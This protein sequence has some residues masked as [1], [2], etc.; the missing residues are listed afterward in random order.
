MRRGS[1]RVRSGVLASVVIL[2][3]CGRK[4][5]ELALPE[6]Q[7]EIARTPERWLEEPSIRLLRDYVRIDTT[8]PPGRERPGAAFLKEY[9]DCEGVAS[10]LVCAEKDRCNLYA[11]IP[12]KN[13]NRALLLLNHIDVVPAY[14][15]D[16]KYPV[17]E[18]VIDRSYLYGRGVYDMKSIGIAQMLAFV[19]LAHS[20]LQPERDVVFLA[21]CG[22]EYG[23]SDGVSWIFE[24]RPELLSGVDCVLNEGGYEETVAG[25]PRNWQ[26]E[27]GQGGS[28]TVIFGSDDPEKLKFGPEIED[29]GLFVSPEPAV[30]RYFSEIAEFRQPFLLRAYRNPESIRNPEI[31]H[32][33]PYQQLS[34]LAGGVLRSQPFS[35][36]YLPGYPDRGKWIAIVMVSLPLGID[37]RPYFDR[38]LE[39]GRAK[40]AGVV[41]SLVTPTGSASPYPS[42]ETRAIQRAL[43]AEHPGV[44]VLPLINSF[45]E[46][47]STEFRKRGIAAYGFTPFEIDPSDAA[48]RHGNDERVFLPFFVRGVET[49]RET[50]FEIVD[51]ADKN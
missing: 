41:F 44:P 22:E 15:P 21:E 47:T 4:P 32:W 27:I 2:A 45:S 5:P 37:P 48:R 12:G 38:L 49:M 24:H 9:L 16:W 19:D 14:R 40:G 42:P 20:G 35:A 18:G 46:T 39:S 17:F 13:R 31:K 3:A 28:A 23:G 25:A 51:S 26:I 36:S 30:R 8:D 50:L 43:A 1:V 29:L 33:I 7:P 10:E 6:W 34:L 11:R